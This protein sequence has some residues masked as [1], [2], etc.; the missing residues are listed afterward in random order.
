M[1]GRPVTDKILLPESG[2]YVR[3]ANVGNQIE[4]RATAGLGPGAPPVVLTRLDA[5]R[6][7]KA[8][9]EAL[10]HLRAEDARPAKAE[11]LEAAVKPKAK[12]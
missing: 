6:V 8:L 4:L 3:V 5:E 11:P 7:A 12:A 1:A 2:G 10:A 9:S